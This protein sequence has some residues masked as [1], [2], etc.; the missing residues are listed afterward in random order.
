MEERG[1][2]CGSTVGYPTGD[3]K[4]TVVNALRHGRKARAVESHQLFLIMQGTEA[5]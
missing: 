5:L 2:L 1:D 3:T 4:D